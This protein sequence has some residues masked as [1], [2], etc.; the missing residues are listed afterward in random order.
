MTKKYLRDKID[1]RI[2]KLILQYHVLEGAGQLNKDNATWIKGQ[3]AAFW[4]VLD[5]IRGA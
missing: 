3:T 2:K 1:A 5:I 4:Y